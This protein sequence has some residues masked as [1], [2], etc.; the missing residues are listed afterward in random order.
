M[1]LRT[2]IDFLNTEKFRAPAGV[3][4]PYRHYADRTIPAAAYSPIRKAFL[5]ACLSSSMYIYDAAIMKDTTL[6]VFLHCAL[7]A[8]FT[9]D[10][11]RTDIRT[12]MFYSF[13]LFL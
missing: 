1:G 2:G 8:A 12:F 11:A 3:R 10:V 13:L 9:A 6:T 4:N 5:S 7:S